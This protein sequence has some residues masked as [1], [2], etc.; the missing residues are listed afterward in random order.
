MDLSQ[1]HLLFNIPSAELFIFPPTCSSPS[2]AS[3]AYPLLHL[4][5][6]SPIPPS[7]PSQPHLSG[8]LLSLP[9][10]FLCLFI[11]FHSYLCCL[12]SGPHLSFGFYSSLIIGHTVHINISYYCYHF[13]Y[14]IKSSL[15]NQ[16]SLALCIPIMYLPCSK[17]LTYWKSHSDS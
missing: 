8:L 4:I 2:V 6:D 3:L 14:R 17:S 12:S 16:A 1:R 7:H 5:G 11:S 15:F 10:W 13:F 9:Q